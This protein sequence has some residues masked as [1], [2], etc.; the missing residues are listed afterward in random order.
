MPATPADLEV[1]LAEAREWKERAAR[2]QAEFENTRKRL[3]AQQAE[4]CA[5]ATDR[6][7]EGL[8]P[9]IDDLDRA[10]AHGQETDNELTAGLSAIRDKVQAIFANEGV[11]VIDPQVGEPFDHETQSAM[12]MVANP[13]LPDM[14][15]AQ[16]FQKGYRRGARVIRPAAVIVSQS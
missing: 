9:V 6:V 14:S 12:Q 5:R 8:L 15:V 16:V 11:E 2:A 4:A 7:I 3:T 1:A 13:D 10:I